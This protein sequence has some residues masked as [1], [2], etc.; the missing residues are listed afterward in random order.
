MCGG[1]YAVPDVQK[2]TFFFSWTIREKPFEKMSSSLREVKHNLWFTGVPIFTEPLLICHTNLAA[3]SLFQ[4]RVSSLKQL[5]RTLL[6]VWATLPLT[7]IGCEK[8]AKNRIKQSERKFQKNFFQQILQNNSP[9]WFLE[10]KKLAALGS[11]LMLEGLVGINMAKKKL[12]TR[13][14]VK[15]TNCVLGQDCWIH[16]QK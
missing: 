7:N 10:T 8:F 5:I 4:G 9:T 1:K 2:K 15:L 11:S 12:F 3:N 6:E 14:K 16:N 13:W